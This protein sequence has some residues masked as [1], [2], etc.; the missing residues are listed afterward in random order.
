MALAPCI[1][2]VAMGK[3]WATEHL[4]LVEMIVVDILK[5]YNWFAPMPVLQHLVGTFCDVLPSACPFLK[6]AGLNNMSRFDVMLSSFPSGQS[7][8]AMLYYW[9]IQHTGRVAL[10]DYGKIK[11][12]EKYGSA[13]PPLV[14][15]EDYAVP[16]AMISG[17]ADTEAMPA[18]VAWTIE[19]IKDHVVFAKE[20][21]G[22]DHSTFIIAKDMSYFNNDVVS[23]IKEYNKLP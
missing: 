8:R 18:D 11:N 20:Y 21:Q 13:Q 4:G 7:Y 10:Y 14:P 5:Y 1:S 12:L 23:V 15:F 16:T 17:S 6:D 9:Q 22:F 2:T 19:Q 3:T